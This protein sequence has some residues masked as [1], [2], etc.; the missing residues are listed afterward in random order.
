ML[1]VSKKI[2]P[3]RRAG[4]LL[5]FFIYNYRWLRVFIVKLYGKKLSELMT[6]VVMGEK[7]YSELVKNPLNYIKFL[8]KWSFKNKRIQKFI[9]NIND[10][11]TS[12]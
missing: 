4:K 10:M 12:S 5:A 7:K 2:L 1:Q 3:E 11:Q 8:F 6:D 9:D